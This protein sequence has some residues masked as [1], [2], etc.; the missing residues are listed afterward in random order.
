MRFTTL[1]TFGAVLVCAAFLV[2]CGGGGHSAGL[3]GG[4]P[5]GP[6]QVTSNSGPG[7][8]V[9]VYIHNGVGK[10][11]PHA[12]KRRESAARRAPK[13]LSTNNPA[14]LQIS[15][16]AAGVT[17]QTVYVD[18]SSGSPLCT[19][20]TIGENMR[21]CTLTIPTVAA[22][23]QISV[24][25]ADEAPANESGSGYG[26]GF[27]NGTEI[28]AAVNQTQSVTVGGSNAFGL[29]LGPVVGYF[30]DCTY[31]ATVG[32]TPPPSLPQ[33]YSSNYGVD[34]S[35]AS[36]PTV[37]AR[38]VVTGGVAATGLMATEFGDFDRGWFDA[39]STPAPFVDVNGS[40]TPITVVSN[41]AALTVAPIFNNGTPPPVSAYVQS[42]S[43]ANDGYEWG[44]CEFFIGVKASSSFTSP[45]TVT[46]NNNLSA[47]NPFT[48]SA[49]P[50]TMTYTVATISVSSQTA[51]VSQSGTTFLTATDFGATNGTDGESSYT[52]NSGPGNGAQD[53]LCKS[54]GGTTLAYAYSNGPI[55]TTTWQQ[56]IEI[57]GANN[58][59]GTCTFYVTDYEA[60]TITQPVTVTVN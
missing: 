3:A 22:S 40:P 44:D 4:V 60:L 13:Y 50:L 35:N 41:N 59:T 29:E 26:T 20:S 31:G 27:S 6:Q 8:H 34:T 46:V 14:G 7:T 38:I 49:Q 19:P 24:L 42:A 51:T 9:T 15:V 55:N 21:A 33:L 58:G 45:T 10:S 25:E 28:L 32:F 54:S 23:E 16:G 2:A 17:T 57:D 56:Q 52:A 37:G 36:D 43:I 47:I 1:F 53:E 11:H 39:D 12:A 18:I 48:S 30:W 5:G